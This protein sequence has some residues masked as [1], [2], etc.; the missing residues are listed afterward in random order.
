MAY[1]CTLS[2]TEVPTTPVIAKDNVAVNA[3]VDV[4]FPVMVAELTHV[5]VQLDADIHCKL[6]VK[7]GHG[8]MPSISG[9]CMV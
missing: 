3:P 4:T 6:I 1:T 7:D 8:S 2:N 9:I 5:N